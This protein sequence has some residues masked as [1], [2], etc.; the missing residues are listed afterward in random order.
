MSYLNYI[1]LPKEGQLQRPIA[2]LTDTHGLNHRASQMY[3]RFYGLQ[4]VTQYSQSLNDM[5]SEA[6]K[7]ALAQLPGAADCI[8][9]LVYCKTQTHNTFS[10][11]NWLRGFADSHGLKNWEVSTLSMTSCASALVQMHMARMISTTDT[12]LIILTGEKT[13]HP[14]VSRL[15]VGLLAEI[16]AAAVFN[17]GAGGW[18]ITGSN[19]RHLPRFHENPDVMS[20]D[21]RRALQE[22]YAAKLIGFIEDSLHKYGA[23]LKGDM[24]F[25][26]HN[27]N[28]PMTQLVL[29]HFGWNA[30]CFQGD[31]ARAGHGFCSDIFLNLEAFDRSGR[32]AS[33]VLVLA[34]GT[35]V[36][37]ATCLL[38]R[39]PQTQN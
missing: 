2:E 18:N 28:Q 27:L 16:P 37:F 20:S 11:D 13:F 17:S 30:C 19:I 4:E 5:L 34:A 23:S 7:G 8:G 29:N 12:P 21:T 39:I 38:D 14:W 33:Q 36:T 6:L 10:S 24:V 9:H 3:E 15:P 32:N 22:V 26:P 35:G 31:I 1:E 25:L